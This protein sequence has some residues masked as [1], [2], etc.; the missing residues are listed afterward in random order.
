[1]KPP[2]GEGWYR[3]GG[4]F[5]LGPFTWRQCANPA[6]VMLSVRNKDEKETTTKPSCAKCWQKCIE[7]KLTITGVRPLT[8]EDK[9]ER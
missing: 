1:M 5:T 9:N 8:V 3:H 4:V 7:E 6:I 2:R